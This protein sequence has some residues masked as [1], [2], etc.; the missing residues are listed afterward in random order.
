[1]ASEIPWLIPGQA[2]ITDDS[3]NSPVLARIRKRHTRHGAESL[4]ATQK[5]RDSWSE[6]RE[7]QERGVTDAY[8][9]EEEVDDTPL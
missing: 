2:V 5:R 1:M 7:E 3:M 6:Y 4:L 9:D 8:D